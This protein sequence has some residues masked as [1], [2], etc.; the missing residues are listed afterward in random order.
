MLHLP[1]AAP[2]AFP[3]IVEVFFSKCSA[4]KILHPLY[5]RG[6]SILGEAFYAFR[7]FTK[8]FAQKLL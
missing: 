4:N 5:L 6:L 3:N 1:C 8:V 7:R 2:S